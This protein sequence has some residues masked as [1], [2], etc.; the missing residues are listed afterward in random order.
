MAGDDD[1]HRPPPID[2]GSR[3]AHEIR[4]S[5]NLVAGALSELGDADEDGRTK[6]IELAGRG[7]AK[8]AHLADR[9]SLFTRIEG[10]RLQLDRAPLDLRDVV[11]SATRRAQTVMGRRRVT[12]AVSGT[13][14]I[15]VRGD[16]TL[17]D[18]ALRELVDNAL[19]HARAAVRIRVQCEAGRTW[20]EIEDDGRGIAPGDERAIFSP[21]G[22]GAPRGNLHLGLAM[23][24][25]IARAHD[26]DVDLAGS[27]PGERTTFVLRLPC[28]AQ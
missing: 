19:R 17:L 10:G 27:I 1:V 23:A 14:A 16:A 4:G 25:A 26:G 8:L 24:R 22:E 15:L 9:L 7:A 3:V 13:D 20:V 12:V 6:L 2:F 21:H 28:V 5:L 11:E 18:M